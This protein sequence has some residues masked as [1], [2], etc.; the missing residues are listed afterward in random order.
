MPAH[1]MALTLCAGGLLSS[2]VW[3]GQLHSLF[4]S[5]DAMVSRLIRA[6]HRPAAGQHAACTVY[7]NVACA[8]KPLHIRWRCLQMLLTPAEVG[9]SLMNTSAAVLAQVSPG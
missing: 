7:V 4:L 6:Q 2:R 9:Y 1:I 5:K 3:A 8:D